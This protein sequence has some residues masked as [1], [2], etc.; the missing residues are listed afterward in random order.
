MMLDKVT[1]TLCNN[2]GKIEKI[3][4]QKTECAIH[5]LNE[6]STVHTFPI[7]DQFH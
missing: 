4:H 7:V 2:Y 5:H 1:M 3:F 6:I